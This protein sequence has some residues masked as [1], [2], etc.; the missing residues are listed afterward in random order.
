MIRNGVVTHLMICAIIATIIGLSLLRSSSSEAFLMQEEVVLIAV[1]FWI[2]SADYEATI[3]VNNTRKEKILFS[4]RV[5]D[6]DGGLIAS[7]NLTA[8]PNSSRSHALKTWDSRRPAGG[9]VSIRYSRPSNGSLVAQMLLTNLKSRTS[10]NF[11]FSSPSDSSRRGVH[12]PFWLPTSEAECYLTILNKGNQAAHLRISAATQGF[13][14]ADVRRVDPG[15]TLSLSLREFLKEPKSPL[16]GAV[17]IV[18]LGEGGD[19]VA[20]AFVA[21]DQSGFSHTLDWTE[22]ARNDHKSLIFP[23]VQLNRDRVEPL[24]LRLM[25]TNVSS[26]PLLIRPHLRSD[27]GGSWEFQERTLAPNAVLIDDL[28]SDLLELRNR[29]EGVADAALELRYEGPRGSLAATVLSVDGN[30]ETVYQLMYRPAHSTRLLTLRLPA[31]RNPSTKRKWNY[32]RKAQSKSVPRSGD[33]TSIRWK[34]STASGR[35][36]FAAV[37]SAAASRKHSECPHWRAA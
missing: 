24:S 2:P 36:S 9:S 1:P 30:L 15:S 12:A 32:S 14:P 35:E 37:W 26:K 3:L 27:S 20:T 19:L 6:L 13:E 25:M 5:H 17:R 31:S 11:L 8:E 29:L 7:E 10:A 18:P 16:E 34:S 21:D 22:V 28:S 33:A 23:S 4:L